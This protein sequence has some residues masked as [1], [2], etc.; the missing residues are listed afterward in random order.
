MRHLSP[1]APKALR[2]C[3][4][5]SRHDPEVAALISGVPAAKIEEAARL[6]ALGERQFGESH[7]GEERGHSSILYAMGITQRKQRHRPG[8]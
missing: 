3:R 2:I 7:Y 1:A 4:Q 8:A 6:Y 5:R